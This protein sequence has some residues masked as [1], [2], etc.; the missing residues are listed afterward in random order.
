MN[1]NLP[2]KLEDF[3][4]YTNLSQQK[5]SDMLVMSGPCVIESEEMIYQIAGEMK[6]IC[7]ELN[8]PYVFKASYDKANRTS[9][10]SFRGPGIDKGL[11][12]LG[13]L[14]KDLDLLVVSDIHSV[15]D[16]E[17]AAEVL[18]IIQIPAFLCRQT[19]IV[20][21]AAKTG[22]IVNIKKGQFLTPH[23][24][25]HIIEKCKSTGNNN[26]LITERGSTFGYNNLVVDFR[27]FQIIQKELNTPVIFDAT[28][29]VQMP[30]AGNGVSGGKSQYVPLLACSAIASE[31]FGLFMETHPN[32]AEALSDGPNMVPLHK[33]KALLQRCKAIREASS[34]HPLV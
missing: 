15:A 23:D 3:R 11:D 12:M 9:V 2:I 32:P 31:A 7:A 25:I 34:K 6:A 8:L 26:I 29:S 20:V 5:P 22:K 16:I 4:K 18:D 30:G 21:A 17:K 28:H 14:K 24:T 27:S 19:D 1:T 10:N 13:Q 33:M